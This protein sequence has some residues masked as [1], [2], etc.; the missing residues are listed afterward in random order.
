[1][2]PWS[3]AGKYQNASDCVS[4]RFPLGLPQ[5]DH[6]WSATMIEARWPAL[7]WACP[8][9]SNDCSATPATLAFE[10]SSC[11]TFRTFQHNNQNGTQAS[12]PADRQ[13][14]VISC[15]SSRRAIESLLPS[16][17]AGRRAAFNGLPLSRLQL[18]VP[19]GQAQR[20][21]KTIF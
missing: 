18:L 5:R 16:G 2:N 12:F 21:P 11:R 6:N 1:M 9:G 4:F 17:Q 19:L 15:N 8:N 14:G 3:I 7:L 20:K 13:I 10:S